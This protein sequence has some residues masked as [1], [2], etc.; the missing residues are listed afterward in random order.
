MGDSQSESS[1]S[2]KATPKAS[3]SKRSRKSQPKAAA[4]ASIAFPHEPITDEDG[5]VLGYVAL[6][7][8]GFV[9]FCS[10]SSDGSMRMSTKLPGKPYKPARVPVELLSQF[11]TSDSELLDA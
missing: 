5:N 10:A 8:E 6:E 11:V 2:K 4:K 1:T 7:R 3:K 9:S